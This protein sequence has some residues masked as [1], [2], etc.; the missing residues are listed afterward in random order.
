MIGEEEDEQSS[1]SVQS[2]EPVQ[3][4]RP[5]SLV[6]INDELWW[7]GWNPSWVTILG[8]L[9]FFIGGFIIWFLGAWY[10]NKNYRT[11]LNN[12]RRVVDKNVQTLESNASE[13]VSGYSVIGSAEI[14]LTEIPWH[15]Q[16]TQRQIARQKRWSF[17]IR[18]LS[19]KRYYSAT[20]FLVGDSS[21]IVKDGVQL[22]M[23]EK[24]P[25]SGDDASKEVYYDQITAVN[26]DEPY[27]E[28]EKSDDDGLYYECDEKPTE[29]LADL[30][31]RVRA[32][33]R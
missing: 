1:E 15:R 28:I 29:L 18:F 22:D 24:R 2:S 14:D 19:P 33:K 3:S 11:V 16:P 12:Y 6:D 10:V 8:L 20:N 25:Q 5:D 27:F 13:G 17:R 7:I 32:Y 23:P 26:Y 21:V 4:G 31:E 30:R 9:L